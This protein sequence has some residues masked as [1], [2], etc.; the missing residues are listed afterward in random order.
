MAVTVLYFAR[1][2]EKLAL[3]QETLPLPAPATAAALAR[4]LADRGG[5]WHDLF[6]CDAGVMVAINE[7][8]ASLASP[9]QDGDTVALFPPVTGG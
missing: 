6:A 7:Q 2:R 4:L 9:L 8:M 3:E 1:F 5:V